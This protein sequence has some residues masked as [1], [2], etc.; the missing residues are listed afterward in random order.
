MDELGLLF[1]GQL[2]LNAD[3]VTYVE[4]HPSILKGPEV[5]KGQLNTELCRWWHKE[6]ESYDLSLFTGF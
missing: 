6:N 4:V 2:L 5:M 1:E 3:D